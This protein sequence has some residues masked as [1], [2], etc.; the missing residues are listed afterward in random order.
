[1]KPETTYR[2]TLIA[3]LALPPVLLVLSVSLGAV[4][5]NP[6]DVFT[7][8]LQRLGGGPED[9][10]LRVDAIAWQIR[11]PRA[12]SAL[13]AGAALAVSG[14]AVQGVFRNPM[15]SPDVLGISAGSSFGAV[16]A[17]TTGLMRAGSLVLPLAAFV[18]ALGAA[19]FV[20]LIGSNRGRSSLLFVILAGL[21]V[22]SLLN[23]MVSALL[24][25][26]ERY[27]IAQFLFWTMGGLEAS[28]FIKL[29]LPLPIIILTVLYLSSQS[30]ALNLLALGDEQAHSLGLRVE[31][32][33]LR[34]LG[35]ASLLT[36]MA[37]AMAGPIGFVGL[38]IPHFLRLIIG[39]DNR[40]LLPLSAL[41]GG[42]FLIFSDLLGRL[43][44]RPFE[45]KTGIITGILGGPYFIYLI[46]RYQRKGRIL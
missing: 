33:K 21:A 41:V 3:A 40:R 15:A 5:L 32:A 2:I 26:S 14:A 38:M 4:D 36:A 11:L 1:M 20:Y 30:R 39:S 44:A 13:F 6:V 23:G 28:S 17:I 37:I 19:A 34:I 29:A 8:L 7:A 46:I 31:S 18:G 42:S 35:A 43:I 24:L 9:R 25:F 45:I 27:E 22:S 16:L 12:L 10:L